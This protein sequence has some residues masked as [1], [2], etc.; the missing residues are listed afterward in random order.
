MIKGMYTSA[1]GMLPGLK[2]QET[3]ANNLANASTSGFKKDVLFT[4]ELRNAER[5]QTNPRADWQRSLQNT[6]DIDYS[7]GV[8][9]KTDNP[10]NLA[11]DGDGFFVLQDSEG[12]TVLT[13]SGAFEVDAEGFLSY[14]GGYRLIGDGGP[15]Q[16]GSGRLTV[17]GGGEAQVNGQS[18]GTITAR[19]V[20]DA[21]A[22]QRLGGSLFVLPE[23]VEL[24]PAVHA[25]IQQGYLE[26]SN[27]DVVNEMVEMIVS[28]RSYEANSK[29]L[30][31]QDESL[32]HLLN[33]VAGDR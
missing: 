7:A 31:A 23:G 16:V 4:R 8:F 2:R 30:Q 11:I 32:S 22:L 20:A 15:I 17:G 1:N 12:G 21:S 3:I 13:R 27:V 9:D 5:R 33:R 19:A 25:T 10:H 24:I 29:S 18:A 28:Y 6:I 26:T 14:P